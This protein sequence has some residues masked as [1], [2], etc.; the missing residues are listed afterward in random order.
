[1]QLILLFYYLS[2]LNLADAFLTI[3][4]V[5]NSLIS[6]ANPLM[7]RLYTMNMGIF[8]SLKLLLSAAL[9]LFVFYKKVPNSK[10]VQILTV[11]AAVCYTMVFG[12]HGFWL[13][14]L[15]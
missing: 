11:F 3:A 2:L 9:L 8:L 1:M 10:I 15:I 14:Q 5:E 12:L 6:E 7:E 13:I 4:G